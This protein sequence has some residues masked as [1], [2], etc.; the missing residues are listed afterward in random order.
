MT[1]RYVLRDRDGRDIGVRHA[2]KRH[3]MAAALAVS[4]EDR[5]PITLWSADERGRPGV[6]LGTAV[7][8]RL[9]PTEHFD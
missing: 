8:G 2:M 3:A 9:W 1:G 7:N 4:R 5:E 6:M